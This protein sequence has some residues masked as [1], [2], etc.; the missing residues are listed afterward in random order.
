MQL[1]EIRNIKAL[2]L[3]SITILKKRKELLNQA[4]GMRRWP[5]SCG[6]QVKDE[7]YIQS[8]ATIKMLIMLKR[9]TPQATKNGYLNQNDDK[10]NTNV[11][12]SC[13]VMV[14]LPL[15]S[16]AIHPCFHCGVK[17]V[18]A[19]SDFINYWSFTITRWKD[20]TAVFVSGFHTSPH[21]H[22]LC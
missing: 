17:S 4:W 2:I 5:M 12:I 11:S 1:L 7:W 10:Y 14:V 18:L 15:H 20:D 6:V 16:G 3:K 19:V 21:F 13:K 9:R 22:R 8:P